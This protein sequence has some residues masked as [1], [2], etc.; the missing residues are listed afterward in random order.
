MGVG[1]VLYMYVVV[2]QK[3]TFAISSPDEFLFHTKPRDWFGE[4]LQN[5]PILCRVGRTTLTQ[6]INQ[7]SGIRLC[8][9]VT[10]TSHSRNFVFNGHCG[11]RC[12]KNKNQVWKAWFLLL[13]FS[14][15]EQSSVWTTW[16][17]WHWHIQKRLK[18]VIF[19][20]AY[21]W[22]LYGAPERC[23][24]RAAPYKLYIDIDIWYI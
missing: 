4:C 7:F 17:L 11:V 3:F 16:Y 2:V 15:L 21:Q 13:W 1:A 19:D 18:S 8:F 9:S 14:C 12:A 23:V 6:S 10:F 24:Y 20:C 5:D 22:L